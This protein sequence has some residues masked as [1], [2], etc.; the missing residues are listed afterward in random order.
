ME[1]WETVR[2]PA[3]SANLG[4]GF[5]ALALA[6]SIYLHC[7]FRRSDRLSIEVEGRDAVSIPSDQT[8]LIW[9]TAADTARASGV[10]LPPLALQITNEIP[11]GKG[12]GSSA[13]ALVAALAIA[14][15]VARLGWTRERILDE[16]AR[17]EGHP[18]NVA[19]C[20][21]GSVVVSAI[22]ADG[23]TRAIRLDMPNGF[24][25][26]AVV[27]NYQL[28]TAQMRAVLPDCYSSSDTIFNV[29]RASLLVAALSTGDRRAFPTALEDRIHQP[30]RSGVVPGLEEILALREP[31]LLGCALSGAGPAVLVFFEKDAGHCAERVRQI[32]TR[33]G[34]RAEI[35]PAQVD[36]DGY[37]LS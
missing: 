35:L 15:R 37:Y 9:R 17:R 6:L 27:P 14:D 4:P 19:A 12:L 20:V 18:D 3:S 7:R 30:Y 22:A 2:V 36:T 13:A 16:A 34:L 24:Q 21:M 25:V 10:E 31:G 23:S 1:M 5:D 26:A 11:V 8:N 32:F 29:Q 28:P 33:E